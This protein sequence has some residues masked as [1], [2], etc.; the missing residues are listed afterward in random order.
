MRQEQVGACLV[1]YCLQGRAKRL[2]AAKDEAK[3]EMDQY[4][5]AQDAHYRN[6]EEQQGSSEDWSNKYTSEQLGR[7]TSSYNTNKEA[8][9]SLLLSAILTINPSVHTNYSVLN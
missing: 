6:L 3:A 4:K 2:K 1:F 8:A 9:L 5:A 7:I